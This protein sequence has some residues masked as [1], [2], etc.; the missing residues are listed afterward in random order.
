MASK[1][2]TRVSRAPV[3]RD[4][5]EQVWLAGLGALAVTEEEGSKLFRTLVKKGDSF[6]RSSKAQIRKMAAR[7]EGL[8]TDAMER[9]GSGFDDAMSSVLHRIGVP[10]S[11]DIARLT[12]RV[13][14]LTE[15]LA[16]SPAARSRSSRGTTASAKRPA[17]RRPRRVAVS[18]GAS[19]ST[20]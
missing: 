10:T 4:S 12:R 19:V 16:S 3:L 7:A 2:P 18:G 6:E 15:T 9:I 20:T 11:T 1:Q 17:A 13:D 5:V 8:R 14:S